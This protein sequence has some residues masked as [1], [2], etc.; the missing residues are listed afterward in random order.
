MAPNV[1][2][3]PPQGYFEFLD[4]LKNCYLVLTDSGG[5]RE[6]AV[7]INKLV[8]LARENEEI[9]EFIENGKIIE[10]G[11]DLKR[12]TKLVKHF[13]TH[14]EEVEKIAA[15]PFPWIKNPNE[16]IIRGIKKFLND[17]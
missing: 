6:E 2:E 14:P 5:V 12:I 8:I 10:A 15:T 9:L 4:L 17:Q 13:L 16:I 11:N 1:L 3:I 7:I